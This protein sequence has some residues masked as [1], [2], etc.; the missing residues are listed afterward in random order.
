MAPVSEQGPQGA[1][2]ED[3][4]VATPEQVAFHFETA[5]L[6][7]RFTAQLLDL[8]VL[9]AIFVALGLAGIGIAVVTLQVA[10][11]VLVFVILGFASFWAYWILPEALWS[12]QT[13]GKYV[14]HLRVIDARGGP[15][16][17]GQAVIRNLLRVVDF[18]PWAYALGTVVMFGT[19]RS[20]RLGDLAAGTIVIR[21]R[22]AVRLD[23][24]VAEAGAKAGGA[25]ERRTATRPALRLDPRLHRF[26]QA[27]AQRRHDLPP[28][29]RAQLARD[30][31]PA[32]LAALPDVVR[33]GGALAALDLLADRELS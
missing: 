28:E 1:L 19:V 23:D 7:S 14:L 22:A 3:L 26:V 16:T 13:V 6:G 9:T 4:V 27:Y 2:P 30:V 8:L 32:L 12:G 17:A 24:L 31:E 15:I 10:L 20:Q 21:E 25:A 5:G 18:L 33:S 29:R 11:G